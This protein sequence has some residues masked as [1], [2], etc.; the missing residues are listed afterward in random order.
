MEILRAANDNMHVSGIFGDLAK[1]S[2]CVKQD[3]LV[4]KQNFYGIEGKAVQWFKS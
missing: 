1:E 4:S 3:I 2:D